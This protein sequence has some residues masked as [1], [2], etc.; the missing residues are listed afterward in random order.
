MTD[1]RVHPEVVA[2]TIRQAFPAI[3]LPLSP[4]AG[5]LS[6]LQLGYG[7]WLVLFLSAVAFARRPSWPAGALLGFCAGLL[8]LLLLPVPGL[9]RGLWLHLPAVVER[10]TYYWP[11]Q[12]FYL[13][14][15]GTLAAAGQLAL[16]REA[17]SGAGR[18]TRWRS[19][20]CSPAAGACG[21]PGNS[22]GPARKGGERRGQRA[23]AAAGKPPD[24]A[25]FLQS[26][27]GI[28]ALFLPRGDRPAV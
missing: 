1:V 3:I 25:L 2:Q 18:G 15:A 26:V 16:A 8:L 5:A 24:R 6:D 11:M 10:I 21:N 22:S 4:A 17:P 14:L 13:L 7:L 19:P 12:R 28:A 27:P 23:R 9:M 20:S